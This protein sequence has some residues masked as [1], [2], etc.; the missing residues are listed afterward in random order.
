MTA[1]TTSVYGDR[2]V[3]RAFLS[4]LVVSV[5]VLAGCGRTPEPVVPCP[6]PADAC[7][8]LLQQQADLEAIYEDASDDGK[9]KGVAERRES[10]ACLQLI[11]DR[12]I[13]GACVEPCGELCRL[14]PC[15]IL[16]AGGAR[17][18]TAGCGARCLEL[19]ADQSIAA[20]DLKVAIEKAAE[21]PGFCTCRACLVED[22]AFC[23]QLFD[24]AL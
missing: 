4:S 18:D 6:A 2:V 11:T 21:N 22:D 16:D 1:T 17:Q 13:D 3:V 14:H 15:V 9:D 20:A 10:A 8:D 12:L 5:V 24:C 23:T 19:V 7:D